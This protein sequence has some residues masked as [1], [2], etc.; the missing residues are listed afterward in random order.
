MNTCR[1]NRWVSILMEEIH[2]TSEDTVH[3]NWFLGFLK[4]IH[5]IMRGG[6]SARDFPVFLRISGM[7]KRNSARLT[8]QLNSLEKV[9]REQHALI[10]KLSILE[11]IYIGKMKESRT[12]DLFCGRSLGLL[13]AHC[14]SHVTRDICGLFLVDAMDNSRMHRN[15]C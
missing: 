5:S 9:E 10:E 4:N 7:L 1:D 6:L 13:Q 12:W 3:I 11:L 14:R 2:F 8:F 15:L